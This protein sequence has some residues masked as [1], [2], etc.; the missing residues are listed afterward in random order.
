MIFRFQSPFDSHNQILF[1]NIN[2]SNEIKDDGAKN[3]GASLSNL[4]GLTNLSIDLR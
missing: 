1:L 4:K 3:L 2:R